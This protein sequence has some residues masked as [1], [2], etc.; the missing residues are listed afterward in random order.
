MNMNVMCKTRNALSIIAASTVL[1]IKFR[2]NAGHL[3]FG[4]EK[5]LYFVKFSLKS[6]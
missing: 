3:I 4:L 2:K 6:R 5:A 1:D